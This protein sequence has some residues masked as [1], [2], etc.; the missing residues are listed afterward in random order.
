MLK[1]EERFTL[2]FIRLKVREKCMTNIFSGYK[3]TSK[4]FLV[5]LEVKLQKIGALAAL[6]N[7]NGN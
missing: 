6:S 4:L 5:Y 7:K 2:P 1:Q 3:L